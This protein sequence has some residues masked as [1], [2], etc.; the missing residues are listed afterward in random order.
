LVF[1]EARTHGPEKLVTGE[2]ELCHL[3]AVVAIVIVVPVV[4]TGVMMIATVISIRTVVSAATVITIMIMMIGAS[5]GGDYCKE[6]KKVNNCFHKQILYAKWH[7]V[8]LRAMGHTP[9]ISLL[10]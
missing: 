5:T 10:W 9:K 7:H 2:N 1:R 3:P 4:I 8:M 6:A